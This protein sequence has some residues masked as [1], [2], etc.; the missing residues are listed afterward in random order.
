VGER[1]RGK[2]VNGQLNTKRGDRCLGLRHSQQNTYYIGGCQMQGVKAPVTYIPSSIYHRGVKVKQGDVCT[3]RKAL[4]KVLCRKKSA[5]RAGQTT[6]CVI[7]GQY[8]P[9]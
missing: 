7:P 2:T 6:F 4:K 5:R 1:S 3:K 9:K 8:W